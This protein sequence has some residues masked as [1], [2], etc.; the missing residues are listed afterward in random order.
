VIE[1]PGDIRDQIVAHALAGAPHEACGLLA[2]RDGAVQHFFTMVNA[3]HSPYTY[4][5]DPKEQI[6]VFEEIES[7]GWDLYGIVHSHTHTEA[8]PSETDRQ[9]AF[10][11]EAYCM[12][13]SLQDRNNPVLR[14]FTIREGV[15]DEVEV[16]IA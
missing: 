10:Y 4:R 6:E 5:L 16:K 15:I 13:V 8:Y 3:D 12:L 11:P 7:K 14:A 9:Q 1:I 2:A